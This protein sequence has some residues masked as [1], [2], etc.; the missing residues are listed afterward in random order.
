M[1][2]STTPPKPSKLKGFFIFAS[3]DIK[4]VKVPRRL[5]G[6]TRFLVKL[7]KLN[8]EEV[9]SVRFA[10]SMEERKRFE[11]AIELTSFGDEGVTEV[12]RQV[13]GMVTTKDED[14][15]EGEKEEELSEEEQK[16]K[17]DAAFGVDRSK[18][19]KEAEKPPVL[20][21]DDVTPDIWPPH[22]LLDY[23]LVS[24]KI[25]D[26]DEEVPSK[27]RIDD[28]NVEILDFLIKEAVDH[29]A[30]AILGEALGVSR[31]VKD[32]PSAG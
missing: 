19:N 11:Q 12:A 5:V 4:E 28:L 25:D 9:S 18:P 23:V 31:A 32:K 15:K 29:N 2:N 6:E 21:R 10:S 17:D 16:K 26:G 30:V 24:W 27:E 20:T 1:S 7:R 22:P 3:Q 14:K 8:H 13:F